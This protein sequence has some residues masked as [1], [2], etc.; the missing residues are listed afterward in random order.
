MGH[1]IRNV[2]VCAAALATF[3]AGTGAAMGV[4]S[5]THSNKPIAYSMLFGGAGTAFACWLDLARATDHTSGKTKAAVGLVSLFA[6]GVA[7]G[8]A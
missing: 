7:F 3:A 2:G 5:A 4:D 6:T 8:A 1:A